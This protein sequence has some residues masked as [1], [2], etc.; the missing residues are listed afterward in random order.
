MSLVVDEHR[1]LLADRVRLDALRRAIAE[2]VNPGSVVLDLASGTGILGLMA[3]EAG[4]ARVYAI[5]VSGMSEIGRANAAANAAAGRITV[6]HGLSAHLNLPE[7]VDV[8]ACD[9]IGRFGIEA[10]LITYGSDARDRFLK[11]GGTFMPARLTLWAAPA[12]TPEMFDQIEFWSRRPGG[13]DVSAARAWA[14]NTGYPHAFTNGE[15]LA[16]ATDCITFD[17]LTVR[18][19]TFAFRHEMRCERPGT[20]HGVAGGFSAQLSPSVTMTNAPSAAERIGRR[21][22]FFPVARPVAVNAG[23]VVTVAMRMIPPDTIAWNVDVTSGGARVAAFRHS[24][25]NGMLLAREDLRRMHP[26]SVPVLTERGQA[27]RSILELCDGRRTLTEIE[28]E[29]F[30]RHCSLFKSRDE[31]AAFVAEV[32]TRYTR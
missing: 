2:V 7:P 6:L 15:L 31:A 9:Q 30:E 23:D 3:C 16:P 19:G 11:P 26:Q 1:G 20:L 32:V 17:M 25:I 12:E 14:A 4:A 24:T 5:E 28:R 27:R 21:N 8:I 22:V 13:F 18:P 10:G 29:M